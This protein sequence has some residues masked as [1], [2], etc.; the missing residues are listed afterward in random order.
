MNGSVNVHTPVWRHKNKLKHYL[1]LSFC[2]QMRIAC[3]PCALKVILV[4][5]SLENQ[6]KMVG[7]WKAS[8][9]ARGLF[10]QNWEMPQ[11]E[12]SQKQNN[13]ETSTIKIHNKTKSELKSGGKKRT[14]C[15][16]EF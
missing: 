4:V 7:W 8:V 10:V 6:E 3:A 16:V 9:R 12:I 13:K 11:R 15:V 5:S 2:R 14:H 1:P